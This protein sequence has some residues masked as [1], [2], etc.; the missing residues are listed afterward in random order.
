MGTAL[1][2]EDTRT[3]GY[4]EVPSDLCP[5]GKCN[6]TDGGCDNDEDRTEEVA[7]ENCRGDGG[8][9]DNG[10]E[11]TCP[12]CEGDGVEFVSPAEAQRRV[13]A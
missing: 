12:D 10:S 5:C 1:G 7:C 8:G 3:D 2:I 4:D 6:A 13:A 9:W 11:W